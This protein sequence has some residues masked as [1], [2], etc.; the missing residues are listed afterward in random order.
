MLQLM[1]HPCNLKCEVLSQEARWARSPSGIKVSTLQESFHVQVK[2]LDP[3]PNP[4]VNYA[5][6]EQTLI[7]FLTLPP[8][9]PPHQNI[10]DLTIPPRWFQ[11]IWMSLKQ[12][13]LLRLG[14]WE[15]LAKQWRLVGCLSHVLN[16]VARERES[17]GRCIASRPWLGL[18]N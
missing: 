13:A 17:L 12:K 16:Q 11:N 15:Y 18:A 9:P 2:L 1:G 3:I 14:L 6:L 4:K 10:K 5:I 8:R 7:L